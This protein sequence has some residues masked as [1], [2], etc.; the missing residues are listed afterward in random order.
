[1]NIKP[2]DFTDPRV[3]ALLKTH[4]EAMRANSP[5]GHSFALDLSGLQ[6]PDISFFAGW[7]GE[8]L[9]SMGALKDLKDG[10][11][12]VKSMRVPE[13]QLGKGYGE[14][15]L[16]HLIA[17]ARR[18]CLNRLS[19]ESGS[20]PAFEPALKLYR[21]HGFAKGPAF[22]DYVQSEFCQFYHLQL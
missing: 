19:L 7:Q 21:K 6:Q 1:M 20:G 4:L 17:Q 11:G 9:V 14:A 16:L 10:T 5:P 8:A 3:K 12:E 15:M 18:R 13:D 22:A 2:G